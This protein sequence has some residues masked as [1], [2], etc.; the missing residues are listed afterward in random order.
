MI[1]TYLDSSPLALSASGF[2]LVVA[3][4]RSPDGILTSNFENC[5]C[6]SKMITQNAISLFFKEYPLKLYKFKSGAAESQHPREVIG[7]G[8]SWRLYTAQSRI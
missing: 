7:L 3:P 8:I 6:D 1:K 4:S 5:H 2:R